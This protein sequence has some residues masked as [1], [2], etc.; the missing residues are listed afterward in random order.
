MGKTAMI[1]ARTEPGIKS[2]VEKIFHRLG[3]S[4]TEAINLFFR[5]V[6]LQ[7]GIPFEIKV[8]NRTTLRAMKL[9]SH[10]KGLVKCKDLD[11]LFHKLGI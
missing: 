3:I 8:P 4:C 7:K 10:K 1:R 2:E 11:E 9:A 5:Q 6:A